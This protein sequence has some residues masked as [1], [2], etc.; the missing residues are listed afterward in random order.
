MGPTGGARRA[1]EP[2]S[3]A[4]R[5]SDRRRPFCNRAQ[6]R[7]VAAEL[8]VPTFAAR[9]APSAWSSLSQVAGEAQRGACAPRSVRSAGLARGRGNVGAR[10][11][12][13]ASPRDLLGACSRL[14]PQLP[15]FYTDPP[16]SRPSQDNSDSSSAS[17]P[18]TSVVG[19]RMEMRRERGI[20]AGHDI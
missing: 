5:A 2:R 3:S 11:Q 17:S 10:L 19:S 12:D 8:W 9:P 4:H 15:A 6:R 1:S 20:R 7:R 16:S 14:T 18:R 13:S